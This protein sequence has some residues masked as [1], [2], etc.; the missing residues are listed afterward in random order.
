MAPSLSSLMPGFTPAQYSTKQTERVW[1]TAKQNGSNGFRHGYKSLKR[2]KFGIPQDDFQQFH[3]TPQGIHAHTLQVSPDDCGLHTDTEDSI[4]IIPSYLRGAMKQQ[5]AEDGTEVTKK[6][7]KTELIK[8][9]VATVSNPKNK[10]PTE[11]IQISL[12]KGT[13]KVT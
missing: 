9:H 10:K 3:Y 13:L 5:I 2:D 12:E 7:P 4:Y 11:D 1:K 6:F 8:T